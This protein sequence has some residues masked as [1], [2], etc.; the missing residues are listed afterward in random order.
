MAITE[1]SMAEIGKSVREMAE[2]AGKAAMEAVGASIL[3][4]TRAAEAA[5]VASQQAIAQAE[6]VSKSVREMAE[7]VMRTAMEATE[8]ARTLSQQAISRAEEFSKSAKERVEEAARVARQT[9]DSAIRGATEAAE[10]TQVAL[11]QAASRSEEINNL[12]EELAEQAARFAREAV[13]SANIAFQ[14]SLSRSIRMSEEARR[15]KEL[16]GGRKEEIDEARN[17][18]GQAVE[19]QDRKQ[20]I[21]KG[22]QGHRMPWIAAIGNSLK[23]PLRKGKGTEEPQNQEGVETVPQAGG[24]KAV[25]AEEK[26][27]ESELYE[28]LVRIEVSP[29]SETNLLWDLEEWLKHSENLKVL[30]SGGSENDGAGIVVSLQKPTSLIRA[31]NAIPVVKSV[32]KG[33]GKVIVVLKDT[34]IA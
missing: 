23:K 9:T 7:E 4:V 8:T 22:K 18:K 15:L 17:R 25:T 3:E 1:V 32:S 10:I 14:G 33:E 24:Q 29:G 30:W 26:D 12:V 27:I 34:A 21:T 2:G 20:A 13:E 16:E 28:G 31:L 11:R 5:R 19:Q 6:E